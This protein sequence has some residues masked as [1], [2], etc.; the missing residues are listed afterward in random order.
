MSCRLEQSYVEGRG[1]H[2]ETVSNELPRVRPVLD[3]GI[4]ST[5]VF[6]EQSTVPFA[7]GD[8]VGPR[9]RLEILKLQGEVTRSFHELTCHIVVKLRRVLAQNSE[10][11]DEVVERRGLHVIWESQ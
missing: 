4:D 2:G 6:C 10:S 3:V 11:I 5:S 7:D 1:V 8:D 9:Q